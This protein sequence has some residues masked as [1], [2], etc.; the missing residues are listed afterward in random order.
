M[1]FL[2]GLLLEGKIQT[3]RLHYCETYV[4]REDDEDSD[5]EDSDDEDSDDEDNSSATEEDIEKGDGFYAIRLLHEQCELF[6]G[7]C[8]T[9]R[10]EEY[11]DGE[12]GSVFVL[13]ESSEMRY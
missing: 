6:P 13:T 7:Q 3:L 9:A 8:F 4:K 12:V 10:L 5:D 1:G 11:P 2:M